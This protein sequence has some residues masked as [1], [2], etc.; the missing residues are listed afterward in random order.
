M[1]MF[2]RIYSYFLYVCTINHTVIHTLLLLNY[3]LKFGIFKSQ[4]G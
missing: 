1:S 2:V 4:K 3:P